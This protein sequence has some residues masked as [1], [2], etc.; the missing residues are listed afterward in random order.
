MKVA[1]WGNGETVAETKA[2]PTQKRAS[3]W[4]DLNPRCEPFS[5]ERQPTIAPEASTAQRA[6]VQAPCTGTFIP[7]QRNAIISKAKKRRLYFQRLAMMTSIIKIVPR[8]EALPK[9]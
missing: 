4:N 1:I 5:H 8:K 3:R 6:L 9:F 2:A 7:D